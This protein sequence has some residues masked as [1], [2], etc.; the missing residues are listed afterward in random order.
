M[1]Q[2]PP[3]LL[4]EGTTGRDLIDS[5]IHQSKDE[6]IIGIMGVDQYGAYYGNL[7]KHPRKELMER[8]GSRHANKI[9]VDT[10]SG[11]TK[12]IGYVID[13]RWIQL[14]KVSEWIGRS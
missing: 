6:S 8:I 1:E 7:G 13:G 14:Y 5:I 10:K 4:E 12:H 9:Y 11:M 2:L 3:E